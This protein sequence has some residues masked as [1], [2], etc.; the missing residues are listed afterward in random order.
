MLDALIDQEY[1]SI[2]NG[3]G[4]DLSNPNLNLN[5]NNSNSNP[6]IN[7]PSSGSG[8]G[9]NSN[10]NSNLNNPSS[11][12]TSG[13]NSNL[14]NNANSEKGTAASPVVEFKDVNARISYVFRDYEPD[15][16]KLFEDPWELQ[17]SQF[18]TQMIKSVID[19]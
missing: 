16:W 13:S 17:C 9:S 4:V 10:S 2:I 11:P 18:V 6:N 1:S 7:H 5:L 3:A 14:N 8:S 15:R 12:V 19:Q